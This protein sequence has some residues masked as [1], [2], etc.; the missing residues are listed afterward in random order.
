MAGK[1]CIISM[2]PALRRRLPAALC[3]LL[4]LA[5]AGWALRAYAFPP[6]KGADPEKPARAEG[7]TDYDVT[8]RYSEE[9]SS[10]AVSET[11]AYRNNTGD[12]LRSL[13]LRTWVNAFETEETSPAALD[14][15]YSACYPEGFSPGSVTVYDVLWNGERAEWTY[16][17]ADRTA[18]SVAIPPLENGEAGTLLFRCV[19]EIPVCS[20]RTGRTG[21]DVAL[22]NCVPLLSRYEDGAWRTDLYSPV[23]DPFVEDCAN[24]RVTAFLPDGFVPAA[25]CPLTRGE[26]GAWR[27]VMYSSRDFALCASPDYVTASGKAGDT[28]VVSCAG[29]ASEARRALEDAKNALQ[30][31]QELYGAYPYPALMLCRVAFPFGGMEYPGLLMIGEAYYADSQAD[32]LELTV[33]HET[34]HQWFY[35][36]VGSDQFFSPWQDEALCEYAMLRYVRARYGQGSYETLKYYRADAPMRESIPGSLTPGTPIDCF[37][38]LRDYA[39]VVYGRGAA[40]MLALDEALPGGAD[41]FLRAYA[42]EFAWQTVS[43]ARFED[44]LNRYSGMDLSPLLLD[45]LD[46]VM[47]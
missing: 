16:V 33:A 25:S 35:A 24:F 4:A 39:A 22:G 7:L 2:F 20:H 43:R 26:D 47:D 17:N 40:L 30:V 3:L 6:G 9:E 29:T 5:A 23:G 21:R 18:L 27:G 13:V 15:I 1:G 41:A 46:T 12:T 34:A 42:E 14:E 38:S 37:G 44:F 8:M 11:I 10:L 19:A 45:Y 31:Y 36:L 32:T 28:L